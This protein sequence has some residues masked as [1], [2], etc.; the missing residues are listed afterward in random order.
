MSSS[1]K[2]QRI[3]QHCGN[4]FTARTTVT[5]Y[6]SLRCS[7]LAYKARKR[8]G[9]IE[10]SNKATLAVKTLPIEQLKAKAFLSIA[11][12]C[13]LVGISRSTVH[14]LINR[15]ELTKGNAGK[16]VIIKRTDLE[17]LLFSQPTN[18]SQLP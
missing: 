7:S 1:I 17:D 3:C 8:A 9:K 16:R 6:C 2:V 4:E 15:G 5:M 11:E 18:R 12:A 10:E 13:K 14:R